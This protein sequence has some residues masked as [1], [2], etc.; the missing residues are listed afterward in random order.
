MGHYTFEMNNE[1][2]L[3]DYNIGVIVKVPQHIYCLINKID[4]G[5]INFS[6][7]EMKIINSFKSCG[8]LHDLNFESDII[9]VNS[10]TAYL[11]FAPTYSCNFRC[12][13]CFGKYGNTYKG[14]Q[15]KFTSESL[16]EML[17]F[18]FNLAF[19]TATK[20]RIDFVSGGEPLLGFDIVQKTIKY[21]EEFYIRTKKQVN[22]WLCTNGSLLNDNIIEYLNYHN[23]SIGI[24]IDGVKEK[25]D[26]N[27]IDE[28]GCGTYERILN[29][30][31]VVQEN[32]TI[33]KKTKNIWG[34]CTATN[35]NCDFI[36]I[37]SHMK[38]LGF[39][40][41]QIRLIRSAISY[42]VNKIKVQYTRLANELMNL[43]SQSDLET[44]KMI[45]N[46]NDQ[47]GKVLKRIILDE[48]LIRRCNAGINK[49][50][51]CPDGTIFPCDSLVGFTNSCLGNI[52][53]KGLDRELYK[54]MTVSDLS[55]CKKCNVKYLCGGDCFYNSLMKTGSQLTV[56]PEYCEIQKHI[57]NLAIKLRYNMQI[58]NEKLF[59]ILLTEVKR[60]NDYAEIFG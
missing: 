29:G 35:E 14:E 39:K 11:S 19:P 8:L 53:K 5:D 24:S 43:F 27:R 15:K 38:S 51:I 17:D 42:D 47:F 20:Y 45:L 30:I 44:I 56:D 34:L 10:E 37:L 21:A 46:D 3:Y 22:V 1:Y 49:I 7:N 25:N 40:N 58:S 28:N 57:I 26:A 32:K 6:T 41:V 13:Y 52:H 55:N 9:R 4:N 48:L 2:Y 59:N 60:K 31:K 18:F 54:D 23:V 12:S 33:S 50:T 36:E 16:T